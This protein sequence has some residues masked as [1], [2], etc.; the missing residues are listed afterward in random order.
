MTEVGQKFISESIK[1][2]ISTAN[3]AMMT[4]GGPGLPREFSWRGT[5]LC[6]TAVLNTWKETGPCRN[7]SDEYYVRKHWFEVETTT[8]L[9]AKIYF[10]RQ[11]RGRK[12]TKR[13]WLFSIEQ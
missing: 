9:R 5:V 10:D 4:E 11:P 6:I 3:V 7:G 13:W 1:P 8:G 2:V 12:L